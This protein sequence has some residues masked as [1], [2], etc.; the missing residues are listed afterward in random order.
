MAF[1]KLQKW[2]KARMLMLYRVDLRRSLGANNSFLLSL[3]PQGHPYHQAQAHIK[4]KQAIIA[5]FYSQTRRVSALSMWLE[6]QSPIIKT[7]M[8]LCKTIDNFKSKRTSTVQLTSMMKR[9]KKSR[10]LSL[11]PP[12]ILKQQPGSIQM[13]SLYRK[14]L[15]MAKRI[16][17]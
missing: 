2:I 6:R 8:K 10:L 14:P 12:Q 11:K 15:E 13:R 16:N 9:P 1:Q 5:A 7:T 3:N 17:K 4:C